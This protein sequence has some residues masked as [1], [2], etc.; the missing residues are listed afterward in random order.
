MI[1]P[2]VSI[3]EIIDDPLN[4]FDNL[5]IDTFVEYLNKKYV[6]K[7][8]TKELTEQIKFDMQMLCMKLIYEGKISKEFSNELEMFFY[9]N[10]N[11]E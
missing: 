6:G 11:W 2:G 1:T 10:I 4:N 3:K 8:K 9:K 7:V 5:T